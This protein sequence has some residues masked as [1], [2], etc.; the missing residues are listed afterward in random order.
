MTVYKSRGM[1]ARPVKN[2]TV[3]ALLLKPARDG[4]LCSAGSQVGLW[5]KYR[6]QARG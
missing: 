5:R 4:K 6:A 1:G 3:Q 2:N